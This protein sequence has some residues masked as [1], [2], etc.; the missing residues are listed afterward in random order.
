MNAV[1]PNCRVAVVMPLHNKG[2]YVAQTLRSLQAQTF[3]DWTAVVV[4]NHSVD[5]GPKIVEQFGATDHRIRLLQAPAEVRG[6]AAARQLGLNESQSEFAL[7]LDADD[8]LERD[9]LES[10][11]ALADSDRADI[12]VSNFLHVQ[13]DRAEPEKIQLEAGRVVDTSVCGTGGFGL[14]ETSIAFA[15][16]PP[17]CGLVRRAVLGEQIWPVELDRY[18][19]EDTAF[20]FRVLRGRRIAFSKKCTA[21]YRAETV[22]ARDCFRDLPKWSAAME[23]VIA[24]NLA[25]LEKSGLEPTA[26]QCEA[27]CRLWES[28]GNR[29]LDAGDRVQADAAFER[30]EVW[31]AKCVA[32]NGGAGAGLA[33]RNFLG[34]RRVNRLK[35]LQGFVRAPLKFLGGRSRSGE[36]R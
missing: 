23:Q 10:L 36:G 18:A 20:W 31:L 17:H 4:E 24:S 3:T 27:L 6:P 14:N 26:G 16:W 11:V 29:A 34:I 35:R 22:N 7:F 9:H 28:I 13:A 32:L 19:G 21:I 5:D 30:A 33:V 15:P 25:H 8:L 2:P 1:A 12:A